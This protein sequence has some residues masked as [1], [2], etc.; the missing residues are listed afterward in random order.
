M[1]MLPMSEANFIAAKIIMSYLL[2][3]VDLMITCTDITIKAIFA[4]D[5]MRSQDSCDAPPPPPPRVEG[6]LISASDGMR[7]ILYRLPNF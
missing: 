4:L 5:G 3:N 6:I 1:S 7:Y 2:I